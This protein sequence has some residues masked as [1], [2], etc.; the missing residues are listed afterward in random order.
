[1]AGPPYSLKFTDTATDVLADLKVKKNL[2]DKAKKVQKALRL[3]REVGPSHPG[4]MTH[5]YDKTRGPTSS[6]LFQSYVENHTSRA[7]RMWWVH[8][9]GDDEITIINIGPHPD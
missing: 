8:G 6:G 7:W 3:L 1:M 4:F 5:K 9:P 2:K